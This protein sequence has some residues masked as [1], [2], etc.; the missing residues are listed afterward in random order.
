MAAK[1]FRM[2]VK[3]AGASEKH[4]PAL[5]R[6]LQKAGRLLHADAMMILGDPPPEILLYGEDFVDDENTQEK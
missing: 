6:A 3:V 4:L 5:I 1:S 2:E